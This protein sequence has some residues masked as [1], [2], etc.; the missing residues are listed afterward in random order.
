MYNAIHEDSE[1]PESQAKGVAL[2]GAPRMQCQIPS[3]VVFFHKLLSPCA[4]SYPRTSGRAGRSA[5]FASAYGR[6]TGSIS[7]RR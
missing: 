6:M 1:T 3:A 7:W 5:T 4:S 2:F